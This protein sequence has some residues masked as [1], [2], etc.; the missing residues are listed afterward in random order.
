MTT[1]CYTFNQA[2]TPTVAAKPGVVNLPEQISWNIATDLANAF[3]LVSVN[4]SHQNQFALPTV[5]L[6]QFS[7]KG[8]FTLP[9]YVLT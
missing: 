6:W 5:Y 8:L 9:P 7:L 2:V 3:F 1:N 4:S